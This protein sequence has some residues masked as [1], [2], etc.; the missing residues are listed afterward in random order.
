M[1]IHFLE[2]RKR[3]IYIIFFLLNIF[4]VFFYYSD[5]IYDLFSIP[6]K[7][8]MPKGSSIIATSMTST[9]LVPLKLSLNLSLIFSLPY[10]LFHLW[11][12]IAPGLYMSEKRVV[13]PFL[14]FSI[15]LFLVGLFFAFYIICPLAINFFM[16]CA[17]SNVVIMISITNYVEFMFSIMI[18]CGISFQIPLCIYFLVNV[19]VFSKKDLSE[20]RSYV[21]IFAF[22]LG[23]L[24][25]PPDVVSQILLALPIWFL[26]EIGLFFSK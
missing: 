16:T 25:T 18:A 1:N 7:N 8:Q 22:I 10:L 21:I 13:K 26:F 6:I 23:M 9:F 11:T 3:I 17:P 19:G 2:L 12:F 20:K 14:F 24:L 15:A 4:V 5:V